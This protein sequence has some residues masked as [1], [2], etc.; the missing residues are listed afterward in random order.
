MFSVKYIEKRFGKLSVPIL[1]IF[2]LQK[3]KKK[4]KC[5]SKNIF[6]QCLKLNTRKWKISHRVFY[7]DCCSSK[8]VDN[9][10]LKVETSHSGNVV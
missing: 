2:L 10:N 7:I 6:Y 1:Y 9:N 4:K 5:N 8:S 3:K